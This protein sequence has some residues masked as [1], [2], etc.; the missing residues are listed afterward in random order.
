MNCIYVSKQEDSLTHSNLLVKHE[1]IW[2]TVLLKS[3]Y[4]FGRSIL[5]LSAIFYISP[6]ENPSCRYQDF[7][8][9]ANSSLVKNLFELKHYNWPVDGTLI[10]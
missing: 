5:P 3:N 9:F 4:C 8:I 1:L 6:K 7:R 10:R 2:S